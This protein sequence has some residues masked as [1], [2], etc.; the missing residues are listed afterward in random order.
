MNPRQAGTVL[1]ERPVAGD[2]AS[3]PEVPD[4]AVVV[5]PVSTVP[6][7]LKDVGEAG[8][9]RVVLCTGNR[10]EDPQRRQ[11]YVDAVTGLAS[12]YGMC[13]VGGNSVGIMSPG[14]DFAATF[15]SASDFEIPTGRM[16]YLAQS[17]A[18]LA[19][20][21]ATFRGKPIGFSHLIS[22]GDENVVSL[23]ELLDQVVDD[24]ATESIVMFLEGGTNGQGL[25]RALTKAR[26]VGKPVAVL[27]VGRTDV[28][29]RAAQS[30]TGRLTGDDDVYRSLFAESGV[31]VASSYEEL[32][33]IAYRFGMIGGRAKTGRRAAIVTTSG[34]TSVVA[35]DGLVDRGW[36][37]PAPTD[38]TR[39]RLIE[40]QGYPPVNP[41]DVT[42]GFQVTDR[43]AGLVD[44]LDSSHEYDEIFLL[45][46]SGGDV[47]EDMAGHLARIA[48]NIST[49]LS[50]SWI[51]PPTPQVIATLEAAGVPVY[52]DPLRA[53]HAAAS[54]IAATPADEEREAAA[55]RLRSL[56]AKQPD[57]VRGSASHLNAATLFGQL[58]DAG[59]AC[60]PWSALPGDVTETDLLSTAH[61][62]GYPLVLKIDSVL[63]THKS[64]VGG[65]IPGI[66]DDEE[67]LR[68]SR[69]LAGLLP[70]AD[71]DAHLLL[72]KMVSGIE[73]LVG[74]RR[75]TTF[76]PVLALGLGGTQAELLA[77]VRLCLLPAPAS[78]ID[79]M[80]A[81]H[82]RL[83]ALLSGYRGAP[84][85]DLGSLLEV[86]H[87]VSDW[88]VGAG[89]HFDEVDFNP[90]IA[91]PDGAFV[92]DARA[93]SA[94]I[95]GV[96]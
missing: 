6:D 48:K 68:A 75:D 37:L 34:G 35:A 21:L 91:T 66:R 78:Q 28:G 40:A 73:V 72:Q 9:R 45:S 63:Q 7:V 3:L 31:V 85:A 19:Y 51:A 90:V 17:G 24:D 58:E 67:L 33:D 11:E 79:E 61:S 38:R 43:L 49:P 57:A 80:V 41:L 26:A 83:S 23:P 86:I 46:G 44:V 25:R 36:T 84:A 32:H 88:V 59:V 89:Q 42:G 12:E 20:M 13:V 64:D 55:E 74:A 27:K 56:S 96:L 87:A 47:A 77:D 54:H 76:G 93:M 1:L 30:H 22:T 50:A 15:S 29:K 65:V 4:L 8:C 71:A 70:A 16:A 53:V 69:K 95:G 2:V 81:G 39:D 5:T 10:E 60:A 94:P 92:V 52:P 82:T 18:A 14:N 62:I